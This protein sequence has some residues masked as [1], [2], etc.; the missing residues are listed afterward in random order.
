MQWIPPLASNEALPTIP[1]YSVEATKTV[2]VT[3]QYNLE[4][5]CIYTT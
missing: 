5:E 4:L 1:T 3:D 2:E